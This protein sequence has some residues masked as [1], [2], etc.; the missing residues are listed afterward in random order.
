MKLLFDQ[1]PSRRLVDLLASEFPASSHPDLLGMR[2]STDADA[3]AYARDSGL[4]IVY[5]DSDSRQRAFL[6]GPPPKVI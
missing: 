4:T 3:W 2:G 6:Q 5:K 1:N